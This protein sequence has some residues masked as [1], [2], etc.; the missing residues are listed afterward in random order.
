M[1]EASALQELNNTNK[2]SSRVEEDKK[3]DEK[4]NMVERRVIE[5]ESDEDNIISNKGI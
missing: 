5:I 4:N 1:A 3:L 2:L